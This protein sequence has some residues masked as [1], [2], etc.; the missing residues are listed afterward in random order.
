MKNRFCFFVLTL[1]LVLTLRLGADTTTNG[2]FRFLTQSLPDGTTNAEYV[3]RFVTANADG[4]VTF[5]ASTALPAGLSLDQ[6]SGFLT[7]IPTDTFN[8]S[9]TVVANDT[10]QP[11]IQFNVSLK[12][13]AAGGGGNGGASFVNTSLEDGRIGTVYLEQLTIAAGVGPFTF[14]AKDLPPGVSLNGQTGVLSGTPTAAGRYFVTLSAY[15]DGENNNSARVLPILV[16]PSGSDFQFVTQSLNNGEV[17]TPFHDA[18]LVTNAAGAVSFAASGLPP[19]LTLDPATG[20]VEGTPTAAGSFEVWISATDGQDT[21]TS[22]IGMIIAPSATSNFYWNVFSLPPGLLGVP[23]DRQPP[24]T[25]AAVNGTNVIHSA[26]GL[27]PGIAYNATTGELTGTPTAVGEF[28]TLFT[29][30]TATPAQVI[31]L[32]FR[33]VILPA[34]GGDISSVPVNFWLTKQKILLGVDGEEGWKGQLLFNADRRTGNRFDPATDN[35]SLSLGSRTLSFPAGTLTGKPNSLHYTTPRGQVPRE[36]V[37]LALSK[38]TVQWSSSRDTIAATVPGLQSVALTLGLQPYRTTVNFDERGRANAF[39]SVRPSFVLANGKLKVRGADS[40]SATL[41]MLMSNPSFIFETGDMLRIRL[42]QEA[43]VLL[44]R[45]FTALG[46]VK[47]TT[48]TD[49]A[50]VFVVKTIKDT[51]TAN[52]IDKFSYNSA[53]GKLSVALSGLTLDTLTTSETHLTIEL[54]IRDRIYT[55][56]VT[57][58]G[59]NPGRYSTAIP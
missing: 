44:D 41:G 22:N 17:G 43:T 53:K 54:T 42:L 9:I 59:A 10:T 51:E 56:G 50:L 31:T 20:V 30:T 7:G 24:L 23:Y 37:K 2:T 35:L 29:A 39:S 28:D 21:I 40:D 5:T 45:D 18:Y 8:G 38:Q 12:I 48:A 15:D 26:T 1:A 57:F 11:P 6:L 13:S 4:P 55:T 34:T 32:Q 3:A 36:S 16:L 52:R 47:Q 19:G 49:G 27:P 46:E 14:G 33:F 58:F 25:A